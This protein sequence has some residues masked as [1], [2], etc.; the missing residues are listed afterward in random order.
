MTNL[1][2]CKGG[3]LV[4]RDPEKP[5]LSKPTIITYKHTIRQINEN[6]CNCK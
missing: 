3:L 5:I 4:P 2:V 6:I 1:Y